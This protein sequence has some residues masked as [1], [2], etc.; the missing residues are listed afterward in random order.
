MQQLLTHQPLFSRRGE[1][2]ISIQ[3]NVD[4]IMDR[5]PWLVE[6]TCSCDQCKYGSGPQSDYYDVDESGRLFPDQIWID[7][8]PMPHPADI[9][10]K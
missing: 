1:R 2:V 9:L 6:V 8:G 3:P 10:F 5:L 7:G 4:K